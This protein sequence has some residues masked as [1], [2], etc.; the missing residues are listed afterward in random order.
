[1][2][3]AALILAAAVFAGCAP[4]EV[5]T[6]RPAE[7]PPDVDFSGLWQL[8]TDPETERRRLEDAVRRTAGT[9]DSRV[10]RHVR[11][12]NGREDVIVQRRLSGGLVQ[13][14][15][16]QGEELKITQTRG[17]LFI[18]FDRAVVEEFRFGEQREIR[19]GPVIADRVSGWEGR[20]YVV[21]TLDENRMKLTER[22]ALTA[23]GDRLRRTIVLR[24]ASGE[25]VTIVQEFS[26]TG[27]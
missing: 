13:L 10:L 4:R 12:P 2:M 23:G 20:A 1:M 15:L 27:R 22:Y 21:D 18:S 11:A 8:V 16:H 14:F 24:A 26:R 17:A 5:L 25:S 6:P 19:V 9:E 7:P 3:R